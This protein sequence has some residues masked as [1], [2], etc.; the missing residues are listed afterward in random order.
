[1]FISLFHDSSHNLRPP[2]QA[3][4][5][6]WGGSSGGGGGGGGG[7]R[8]LLDLHRARA[9]SRRLGGLR[10][11]QI[12]AIGHLALMGL[13]RHGLPRAT[14]LSGCLEVPC[15]SPRAQRSQCLLSLNR[16]LN[17]LV[18]SKTAHCSRPPRP[19]PAQRADLLPRS[20]SSRAV[21]G[22][23]LLR[24]WQR[25][26]RQLQPRQLRQQRRRSLVLDLPG[27]L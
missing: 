18:A 7:G 25:Q 20:P 22:H 6:S 14:V 24:V 3:V 5:S 1:M 11:I 19:P 26:Q 4:R 9:Q 16:R 13:P 12:A 10:R 2:G 23:V 21:S 15:L 27:R 8:C 17:R